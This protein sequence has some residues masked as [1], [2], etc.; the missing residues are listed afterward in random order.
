[1]LRMYHHATSIGAMDIDVVVGIW[2][3]GVSSS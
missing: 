1:M 3:N 2:R